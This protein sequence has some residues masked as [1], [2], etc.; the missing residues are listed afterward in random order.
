[1]AS[2]FRRTYKRPIPP[3]SEIVTRKGQ[4]VARWKDKRG[5]TKSA[6]LADDGKQI[7]LE[8]RTWYIEYEGE[9]GRRIRV[10][11]YTDREATEQLARDKEKLAERIQSGAVTVD[12]DRR[13]METAEA[14]A[15]WTADLVRRGKSEGYV[16]N[17]RH[18]VTRMAEACDWPTLGSIRSDTLIAWLADLQSGA[19]H[20]S[21]QVDT[22]A[23]STL[24]LYLNSAQALIRWCM[25]QR[26]P[27]MPS[28][29]LEGVAKCGKG[30]NP[31]G[32]SGRSS[33][34]NWR[35]SNGHRANGG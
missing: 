22:L 11:G 12:L 34:T 21:G 1:M 28:N 16:Y 14:V 2:I 7:V 31:A 6:P 9:G 3:G 32:R 5:R 17:M 33:W 29:P 27:W 35:D 25:A 18:Y 19:R 26:P 20:I 15:A 8:Y 4:R 30:A 24:N 23:P 10:R 13:G